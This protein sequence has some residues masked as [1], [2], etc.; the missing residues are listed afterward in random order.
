MIILLSFA[1]IF[2]N[3]QRKLLLRDHG[4][5]FQVGIRV[6]DQT[7]GMTFRTIMT[8]TFSDRGFLSVENHMAASGSDENNLT[9]ALMRVHTYRRPRNQTA[10]HYPV[11]P[12]EKHLCPQF[13]LPSLEIRNY[14]KLNIRKIHVHLTGN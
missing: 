13:L 6:I 9:T 5:K 1:G 2:K 8:D 11:R 10:L 12:V 7:V 14:R 3:A 4:Q